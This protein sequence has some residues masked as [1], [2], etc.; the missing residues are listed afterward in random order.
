[1][2]EETRY[3]HMGY[4]FQL[5][6]RVLLYAPSHKQDSTYHSLCYTS[7]GALAGTRT[8]ATKAVY[9]TNEA[10]IN[11]VSIYSN[12]KFQFNY[13][14]INNNLTKETC[15]T[16]K[17]INVNIFQIP[18]QGNSCSMEIQMLSYGRQLVH[19]F[20]FFQQQKQNQH[21]PTLQLTRLSIRN[22]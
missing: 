14:S 12:Y 8:M 4:S 5:T 11:V 3:C 1:M 18:V 17:Y 2:R 20:H 19:S 16:A 7:C 6:A 10:M 22:V 13:Y 9:C 21:Y 15:K